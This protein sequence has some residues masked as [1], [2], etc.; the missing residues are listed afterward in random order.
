LAIS[1]VHVA[2]PRATRALTIAL[3]ADV[4]TDHVGSYEKEAF[5]AV[6]R[7]KADLILFAGD[8]V[9]VARP[10]LERERLALRDAMRDSGLSAPLGVYA[11]RGNVDP[12]G[13]EEIFEG[14]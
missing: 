1:H 10:E 2:S 13:W 4:Q 7:E 12:N 8:Y 3:L 5:A 14:V 6:M 11:V 9:Q